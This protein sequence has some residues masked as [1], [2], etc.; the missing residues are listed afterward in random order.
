MMLMKMIRCLSIWSCVCLY[1]IVSNAQ[2]P[3]GHPFDGRRQ[4][5]HPGM[6]WD[7][8]PERDDAMQT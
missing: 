2:H 5:N 1:N 8:K 3:A 6:I 4:R 7:L